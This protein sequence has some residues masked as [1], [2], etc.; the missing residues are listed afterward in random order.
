MSYE[1]HFRNN[2]RLMLIFDPPNHQDPLCSKKAILPIFRFLTNC[3][4]SGF[5]QPGRV[6]RRAPSALQ[7]ITSGPTESKDEKCCVS[8][9]TE[10]LSFMSHLMVN[11][12]PDAIGV[13]IWIVAGISPSPTSVIT[14]SLVIL[15]L[16]LDQCFTLVTTGKFSISAFSSPPFRLPGS[17]IICSFK[18]W[19]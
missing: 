16:V 10:P 12:A 18:P 7:P 1:S 14:T 5:C 3:P 2:G 11:A 8:V 4:R 15:S 19:N 13:G 6:S 17:Y 9:P